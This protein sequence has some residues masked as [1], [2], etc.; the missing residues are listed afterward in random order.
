[1]MKHSFIYSKPWRWSRKRELR[2]WMESDA[3][4]VGLEAPDA[5][6]KAMLAIY[7]RNGWNA[8]WEARMKMMLAHQDDLC[9]PYDIAVNY[10]RLGKPDLAFSRIKCGDRPEVLGID[11]DDG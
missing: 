11:L 5:N 4:D 1:M 8:Y 6:A 3:L 10:I 2:C 9:G 7:R